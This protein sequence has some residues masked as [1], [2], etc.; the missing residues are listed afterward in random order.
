MGFQDACSAALVGV[1]SHP[2]VLSL[3]QVVSSTGLVEV[4]EGPLT[5]SAGGASITGSLTIGD[6]V[7]VGWRFALGE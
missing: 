3:F 1:D 7:Q 5:V 6:T 4:S 2:H